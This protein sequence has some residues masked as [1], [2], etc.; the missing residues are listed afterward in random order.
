MDRNGRLLLYGSISFQI[1]V[2]ASTKIQII[3]IAKSEKSL[4]KRNVTLKNIKGYCL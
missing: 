2:P 3:W 4:A 1:F